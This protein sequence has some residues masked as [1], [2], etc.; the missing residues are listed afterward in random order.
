MR[1]TCKSIDCEYCR[2][3]S[4]MWLHCIQSVEGF[5][6]RTEVLQGTSRLPCRLKLSTLSSP[7]VSRLPGPQVTSRFLKIH[8][9]VHPSLSSSPTIST[10]SIHTHTHTHKYTRPLWVLFLWRTLTNTLRHSKLSSSRS[11]ALRLF[12]KIPTTQI[13]QFKSEFYLFSLP[14]HLSTQKEMLISRRNSSLKGEGSSS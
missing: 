13:I 8:L 14:S 11:C 2:L 4:I 6:E 1:Y 9:S 3:S 12:R 5:R 10:S 7:W